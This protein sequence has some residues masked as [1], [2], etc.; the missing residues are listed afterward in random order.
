MFLFYWGC[1]HIIDLAIL[2]QWSVAVC[3]VTLN[4]STLTLIWF[5]RPYF[6]CNPPILAHVPQRLAARQALPMCMAVWLDQILATI[7][8]LGAMYTRLHLNSIIADR[9]EH[10]Y[11]ILSRQFVF[12]ACVHVQHILHFCN[13]TREPDP[14]I[15]GRGDWHPC[16]HYTI[17]NYVCMHA[18]LIYL[19]TCV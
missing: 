18:L 5:I 4:F 15:E 3:Q 1:L 16:V 8:Q 19:I 7:D 9:N 2:I 14:V 11:C 13:R 10:V 12:S 17:S 6:Y